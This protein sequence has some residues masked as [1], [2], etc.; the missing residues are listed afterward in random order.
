[1]FEAEGGYT[2]SDRIIN[3][4]LQNC[5]HNYDRFQK[6]LK[7]LRKAIKWAGLNRKNIPFE[8]SELRDM[9]YFVRPVQILN[10]IKNS[11]SKEKMFRVAMICQTRATGLAGPGM[12]KESVDEFLQNVTVKGEFK[13]NELLRKCID[14]VTTDLAEAIAV[15]T[16]PEFKISMSTSACAEM[17]RRKEGKFGFLRELVRDLDIEVPPLSEGVPGSIGNVV[18]PLAKE[19]LLNFPEDVMKVNVCAIRENGKARIVTSGSFWKDALLQPFSH[20]TIHLIKVFSNLR[21]GLK[22][23]RLGW[24]YIEKIWFGRDSPYNWIIKEGASIFSTDWGKATDKPT[25]EMGWEVVGSLLRKTGLDPESMAFVKDYWLGPKRLYVDG[26]YRGDLVR[27]IPMGDPLT[28]TCLSLAHPICDRYARIKTGCLAIEEGNGDDT[29]AISSSA[30]YGKYHTEAAEMLGYERSPMDEAVSLTWATYCEEWFYIPQ[31]HINTTQWGNRFQNSLLLP[32]LDTVKLRTIIATEKDRED[33][34][35]D[36]SGKV[37]L[38]GHDGEYFKSREPGPHPTIY[39]IASGFQDVSLDTI[40]D[41]KPLFLPRQVNGIGKAPPYWSVESYKNILKR[42]RPWHRKY[43]LTVMREL[44]TP[45][46]SGVSRFKGTLKESKHFGQEMYV[47]TYEIPDDDPIKEKILVRHY[48]WD[49]WPIG[50]LEKLITLGYLIPESKLAKY[51]LFQERLEQLTS[52]TKRDLFERVQ[53]EL[54][55]L[56]DIPSEEEERILKDF[57]RI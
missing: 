54:D 40:N 22:A 15:G 7:K 47:E 46:I 51:Y 44:L 34:S 31:S 1:M 18:W 11:T 17:P 25:P 26:K 39:A 49:R 23:G 27:G 50:V 14:E 13:P 30:L 2:L 45:G 12:M 36:P 4:V 8:W 42:V 5:F 10:Q 48:E 6:K 52:D 33:F 32:Y 56:P 37:T 53:E 24:R 55:P 3:S 16:N 35:S 9:S 21:S 38:L 43:Y 57:K 19:M 41:R 20:I 29:V 28:K